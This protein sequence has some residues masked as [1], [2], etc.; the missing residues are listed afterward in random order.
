[1]L[2]MFHKWFKARRCA[3][4]SPIRNNTIRI[5]YTLEH[6]PQPVSIQSQKKTGEWDGRPRFTRKKD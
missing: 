3:V 4:S 1:M 5:S 2:V 6:N